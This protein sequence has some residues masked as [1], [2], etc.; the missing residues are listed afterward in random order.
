MGVRGSAVHRNHNPALYI[1]ELSP[2]NHFCHNGYLSWP[3]LGK[4]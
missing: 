2:L 4:Y 3:Y 1:T